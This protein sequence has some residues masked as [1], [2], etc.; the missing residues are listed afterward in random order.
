M[1]KMNT[2]KENSILPGKANVNPFRVPEGYFDMLP[3]RIMDQVR[4]E[5]AT[6]KEMHFIR[7]LHPSFGL[8]AG[9]VIILALGFI[10]YRILK[11]VSSSIY[12]SAPFNEE[13]FITYSMDDQNIYETLENENP[14][15]PFDNKQLEN[16]ILGSVNEY[17]LIVLNDQL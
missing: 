1:I 15:T 6:K 16:V 14:E 9:F 10:S 3:Q 12:Q 17:E 4:A 5:N 7:F 2:N 13:Y 8:V 11:P